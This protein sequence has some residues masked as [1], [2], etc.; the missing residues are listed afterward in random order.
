M[1][2]AALPDVRGWLAAHERLADVALALLVLVLSAQPLW[3]HEACGCEPVG[4]T[5]YA[6]VAGQ[7]LPL[8][9]RRRRPFGVVLV[10]GLLA[11][12]HGVSQLPEPLLPFGA[13]VALYSVAAH[14]S[15]RAAWTAAAATAV[16]LA[17]V[18]LLER[19]GADAQDLTVNYLVFATA[20]LLGDGARARRDRAAELEAR[21]LLLERTRTAE[22]ERAVVQERAR[23]AREMHD[24]VAH[25]V[26]M[27]VVQAEAGPVVVHRDPVRAG[28]AFDAISATGRAALT[29]MR[30]MLGV[31]RTDPASREPQPG[32]DGLPGLVERCRAAGLPVRLEVGELPAGLP[33][34]VGLSVYRIVQESLTNV[35]KHAGPAGA[36]VQV[37]RD[38]DAV[39]V[40]VHDDGLGATGRA[41]AP[42]PG[43]NG[44][45]G[46]RERAAAHGG[47]LAAGPDSGRGWTVTARLPLDPA[48][49]S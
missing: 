47:V 38:G 2:A 30:R 36:E 9:G 13:A 29:E 34:G 39:L 6:L 8:V 1:R 3:A 32:L 33:V 15:R 23:I 43:G 10:V 24:V 21:M 19:T 27:M 5:G 11:A 16:V 42:L 25:H 44:L 20:W 48:R 40:T 26:S 28:Q 17:V 7:S 35:L 4:W 31:L 41:G 12:V 46:M 37:R 22:A 45:V 14:G 49:A 18:L